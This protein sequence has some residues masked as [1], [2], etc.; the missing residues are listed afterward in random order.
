MEVVCLKFYLF[1]KAKIEDIEIFKEPL[2]FYG[3]G[4]TKECRQGEKRLNGGQ[5]LENRR[6][7][8]NCHNKNSDFSD[9]FSQ[10]TSAD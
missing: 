2:H 6:E 7:I 3:G 4:A 10:L 8:E 1:E 5:H 9:P